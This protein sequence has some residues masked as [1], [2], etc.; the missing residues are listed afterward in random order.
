MTYGFFRTPSALTTVLL[1]CLSGSASAAE[2]S[3]QPL[4]LIDAPLPA[5]L[6][7]ID[8]GYETAPPFE[9]PLAP[10]AAPSSPS[11][12]ALNASSD[13]YNQPVSSTIS[14]AQMGQAQGVALSGGQ[15][16]AGLRFTLSADQVVTSAHLALSS[17]SL[18]RWPSATPRY[19]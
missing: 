14:V 6:P 2:E 17:P 13:V 11:V 12:P 18:R 3:S 16:Q 5:G 1:L 4:S 7:R 8:G 10:R 9:T 19:S 15:L